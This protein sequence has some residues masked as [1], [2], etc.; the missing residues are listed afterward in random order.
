MAVFR[1]EKTK[2]YTVMSNYHLRDRALSLK[3]KGLLSLML[4]LPENWDYT[5]KGL[6]TICKDG[7]DSVRKGV[8]E[9]EEHGYLTRRRIR[10]DNGQL[11]DIEYTILEVPSK[12]ITIPEN[13][14]NSPISDKPMS[15]IP[16]SDKPTSENPTQAFPAYGNP[17]QSITKQSSIKK[18][19]TDLLNI[20]QS[21][22]AEQPETVSYPQSGKKTDTIDKMDSIEIYTEIIKDNIDF[23]NLSDRYR[24]S[25]DILNEILDLMVEAVC[26]TK[27]TI[28]VGG[29]DKPAEVVK[30]RMLKLDF[31]HIEYVLECLD[32]NTTDIRNIKSYLLTAIFNAPTTIGSYYKA[33]VNHDFYGGK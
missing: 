16:T 32:K 3:G 17:T 24:T 26:T 33:Q 8:S 20:H 29:E 15:V 5:L 19:N 6:A 18:S 9:L 7:I 12:N 14:D 11:G 1:I 25:V 22:R 2:D 28:R 21:I 4:S 31:T 23:D 30:S 27:K 13:V 10:H